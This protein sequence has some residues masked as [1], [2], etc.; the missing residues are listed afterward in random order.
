MSDGISVGRLL[1]VYKKGCIKDHITGSYHGVHQEGLIGVYIRRC[2]SVCVFVC[3]LGVMG[4]GTL[5]KV[6]GG[7]SV[8]MIIAWLTQP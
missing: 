2:I 8:Q 6:E 1:E 7:I 5:T 3:V 4:A